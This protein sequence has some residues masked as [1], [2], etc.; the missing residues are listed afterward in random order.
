MKI[1]WIAAVLGIA[2]GSLG[3]GQLPKVFSEAA[4][5]IRNSADIFRGS[6]IILPGVR[7]EMR[8]IWVA[9]VFNIDWPTTSSLTTTNQQ[10]EAR[11]VLDLCVAANINAVFLQVRSQ[12]DALYSSSIEPWAPCL[13][14][15]MGTAPSPN[16]D[17]LSYWI[18]Q[19]RTR[20]I[21]VYAW[22]NP[23]RALSNKN[24]TNP[25]SHIWDA[26]PSWCK[27][28]PTSATNESVWIEP[29]GPGMT[30]TTNVIVD[31]V[32]RYDVDGVVFDDYF[33]PYPYNNVAFPDSTEYANYQAG[34]GL[35]SLANWRRKNVDDFVLNV[36]TQIKLT[37]PWVKFGIGPFGIWKPGFPAGVNGLSSY[38]SLYADTKKWINLG[39]LDFIAPQ[40]YWSVNAAQQDYDDLIEWWS[41]QNLTGKQVWAS[42]S[43]SNLNSSWALSEIEAQIDSTR[44]TPGASGNVFYS[45]KAFRLNY[46]LLQTTLAAGR[47]KEPSLPLAFS[48]IDG[49]PPNSPTVNLTYNAAAGT[50]TMSWTPQGAEAP[51]RY[52]LQ[53]LVGSTWTTRMFTPSTTSLTIPL[54][55]SG[56]ALR[57]F[58]VCSVDRQ[59][60][61]SPWTQRIIDP[62]AL[63][64]GVSRD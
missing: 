9:T 51:T 3:F 23:Y 43:A 21:E 22:V 46:D 29:S 15:T 8:A 11:N 24:T 30:Q 34:G 18:T 33:Y 60:N 42:N 12:A 1:R 62:T 39:W 28:Y 54:K 32:N 14:G 2:L 19:A 26:N 49:T 38:D 27:L 63:P 59:N 56:N 50:Q 36:G 7:R 45:Q 37:K 41:Q 5:G 4:T 55:S 52:L 40:L 35:L 53:Y 20:G 44:N 58:G 47:Y 16:Y 31:I 17:P 48:W 13:R 61:M 6:P 10:T 64:S 25:A 57:A